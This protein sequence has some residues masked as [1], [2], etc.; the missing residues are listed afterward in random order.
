MRL[1]WI[2]HGQMEARARDAPDLA[3]VNRLLNEGEGG[4]LTDLG[5]EQAHRVAAWFRRSPVD[6]I[7]SSPL[8]RA[9]QTAEVTAAALGQPVAIRDELVEL[10]PGE[11]APDSRVAK[12]VSTVSGAPAV[13]EGAKRAVLGAVLVPLFYKRWRE[14]RTV[15][16]ESPEALRARVSRFVA[17]VA[18]AH[19]PGARVAV[20]A[21]G[22]LI[23]TLSLDIAR[24]AGHKLQIARR[25]YIPNGAVTE[26]EMGVG[27]EL[28]LVRFADAAHLAR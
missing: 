19:P 27:G 24:S 22:Y 14:G 11:L 25:P 20:F 12:L 17:E 9:R 16:G 23:F 21:H 15:G 28:T 4:P 5:L 18:R 2:R 8:P 13:P 6:V 7:Y 26:M 1:Y 3:A 10:R